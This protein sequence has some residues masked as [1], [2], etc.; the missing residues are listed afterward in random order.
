ML[1]NYRFENGHCVVEIE[2]EDWL[3]DTGSPSTFC[4]DR[5]I[6]RI[7]IDGIYYTLNSNP[8]YN[9][10]VVEEVV[11]IRL[12]GIIGSD[13]L[14][15]TSFT[16]NSNGTMEFNVNNVECE[17]SI[18]ISINPSMKNVIVGEALIYNKTIN[19]LFETGAHISYLMPGLLNINP[20][21]TVTDKDAEGRIINSELFLTISSIGANEMKLSLAVPNDITSYPIRAMK[22]FH[23][24][25]IIGLYDH[26]FDRPIFNKCYAIDYNNKKLYIE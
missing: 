20:I 23:F 8:G 16:L 6:S 1:Y 26:E 21:G 12:K 3:L 25:A 11:G 24:N 19:V 22:Q 2:G 18:N 15:K 13:L 9:Q 17:N 5:S 7:L 14:F 4:F 10:N